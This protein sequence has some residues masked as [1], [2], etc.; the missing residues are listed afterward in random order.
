MRFDFPWN[1]AE[2]DRAEQFI[3]I[4]ARLAA[5]VPFA[6]G[7]A[8]FGFS[9]WHFD[10]FARD[11]V[12]AML[13]RYVGFDHSSEVPTKHMRNRTPAAHWLVLLDDVMMSELG[14]EATLAVQVPNATATKLVN[15]WLIRTAKWPPVGDI[16]RRATDLGT[17]PALAHW[18]KPKRVEFPPLTGDATELD[19]P[20]WLARF[21]S[22]EN[23]PWENR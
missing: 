11:Q 9:H 10:R 8:G 14:G 7:T 3:D 23:G 13:P 12:Y 19:A 4:V 15:G 5:K 18:L 20:A 16:N 22:L 1:W 17:I 6:A 2:E 21:D